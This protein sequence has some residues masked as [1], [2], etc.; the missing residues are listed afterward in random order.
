MEEMEDKPSLSMINLLKNL[1]C[2]ICLET[3]ATPKRLDC[4]HY[5]CKHCLD[6]LLKFDKDGSCTIK[7]PKQC[8]TIT[9]IA[10]G[11]LL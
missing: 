6:Q 10:K 11:M 5:F 8:A 1:D 2:A 4:N 9:N 7:C 3:V